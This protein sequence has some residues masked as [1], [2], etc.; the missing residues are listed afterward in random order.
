MKARSGDTIRCGA[1][2]GS[3]PRLCRRALGP[4]RR[5]GGARRSSPRA[6]TIA[7]GSRSASRAAPPTPSASS[8]PRSAL[9]PDFFDAQYHLGATQWWVGNVDAALARPRGRGPPGPRSRRGPLLPGA[10][11]SR[12]RATRWARCATCARRS[13]STPISRRPCCTSG[14]ALKALGDPRGAVD[15]LRRAV[16][17]QPDAPTRRTPWASPSWTRGP[18]RRRSRTLPRAARRPSRRHV[19]PPQP[20]QRAPAPGRPRRRDRRLPR[21]RARRARERRGPLQPGH[22]AEAEGRL[23]G[24]AGRARAARWRSIPRCTTRT[25]RWAWCSGRRG[26]ADEAV[27]AFRTAIARKPD[28]ADAHYMLGTIL[29]QQGEPRRRAGRVPRGD[30]P[31]AGVGR[32]PPEPGPGPAAEGRP[33]GRRRRVRGSAAPA[34]QEGRRA[35]RPRSPPATPPSK[36]KRGDVAGAIDG[37]REAVRLDPANARRAP[38]ARRAR[39]SAA[40]RPRRGPRRVRGGAAASRPGSTIPEPR[41]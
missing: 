14:I 4:R 10:S 8:R 1:R 16:A 21:A 23:R 22:G 12:R 33:R 30:P 36:L 20:R 37:F 25:T 31:A 6:P 35:R 17:L 2:A 41:S 28:L 29:R 11:P 3:S 34:A 40:G 7:W 26:S 18:A 13:R 24:R 39:S 15:V 32:G 27:A 38:A 5:A 9:Q 19:R